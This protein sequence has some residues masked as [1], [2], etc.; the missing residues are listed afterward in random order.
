MHTE[1]TPLDSTTSEKKKFVNVSVDTYIPISKGRPRFSAPTGPEMWVPLLEKA[2][3]K[4]TGSYSMLEGGSTAKGI[5][6]LTGSRIVR[7]ALQ[8]QGWIRSNRTRTYSSEQL[9]QVL[10]NFDLQQ[11]IMTCS[12][13]EGPSTRGISNGHAFTLLAVVNVGGVELVR[14][15][16][17]WGS[18]DW[19]GAWSDGSEEW[20][21]HPRIAKMFG[22]SHSARDGM[23]HNVSFNEPI[24][25]SMPA[26]PP[27]IADP[28]QINLSM[29]R[30]STSCTKSTSSINPAM[31][32]GGRIEVCGSPRMT[33]QEHIPLTPVSAP[34]TISSYSPNYPRLPAT[35][36]PSP[37]RGQR[38]LPPGSDGTFFMCSKDFFDIFDY[39]TVGVR[40]SGGFGDIAYNPHEEWHCCGPCCG[41]VRGCF[42]FWCCCYGCK[43]LFCAQKGNTR[44]DEKFKLDGCMA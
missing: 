12:I 8:P 32:E 34:P 10:H 43:A 30:I 4:L 29:V 11:S 7:F 42:K 27:V 21:L 17:P 26:T 39:V 3:A 31:L 33:D 13:N 16:N 37:L 6:L 9:F 41:L 36:S 25:E 24:S 23:P 18:I 2:V 14:L 40:T 15:R 28:V 35:P 22:R 19:A 1:S 5:E 38:P 20:L 44:T